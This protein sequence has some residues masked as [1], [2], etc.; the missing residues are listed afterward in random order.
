ATAMKTVKN[1]IITTIMMRKNTI[2]RTSMARKDTIIITMMKNITARISM[3]KRAIIMIMT[4]FMA[5]TT[6][7]N[8]A[9]WRMSW[10]SLTAL[11]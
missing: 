9:I 6:I 1:I 4:T 10:R 7:T 5:I 8:T 3:A 11:P 2:A